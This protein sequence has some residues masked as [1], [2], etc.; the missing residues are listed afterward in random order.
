MF[1]KEEQKAE[2]NGIGITGFL[3]CYLIFIKPTVQPH[4][5]VLGTQATLIIFYT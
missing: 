3:V 2:V 1:I 4:C 5:H